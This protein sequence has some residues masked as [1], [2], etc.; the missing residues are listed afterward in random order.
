MFI[1]IFF[2]SKLWEEKHFNI[3]NCYNIAWW[4]WFQIN[5]S[6]KLKIRQC[7]NYTAASD[8]IRPTY[9]QT[10]KNNG[11]RG[12]KEIYLMIPVQTISHC[13]SPPFIMNLM[14]MF[15]R[16]R[17]YVRIWKLDNTWPR[18]GAV[19]YLRCVYILLHS[20]SNCC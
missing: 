4:W 19:A 20:F 7:H 11:S 8:L 10:D 9:L 15:I 17:R 1:N 2:P 13:D 18:N 16:T 6:R 12:K 3:L 14:P 5:I